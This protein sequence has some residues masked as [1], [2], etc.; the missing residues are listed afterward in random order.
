MQSK[1]KKLIFNNK[2]FL[3]IEKKGLHSID[4]QVP[5]GMVRTRQAHECLK[6]EGLSEKRILLFLSLDDQLMNFAFRNIPNVRIAFFAQPNIYD[7][8]MGACWVFLKKNMDL[9]RDMVEKWN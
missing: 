2:L 4:F 6:R 8:S 7:L 9:F 1:Q 3:I 5:E